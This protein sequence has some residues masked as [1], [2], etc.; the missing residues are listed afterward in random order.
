LR[1]GDLF[2]S[3]QYTGTP[4]QPSQPKTNKM[5][6]PHA[7]TDISYSALMHPSSQEDEEETSI[8]Q[9]Q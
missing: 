9:T 1:G 4:L 5:A 6:S 2:V 3:V 7:E 8:A